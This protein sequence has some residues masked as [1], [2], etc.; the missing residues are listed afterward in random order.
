MIKIIYKLL[1]FYGED[2]VKDFS[3]LQEICLEE[4]RAVGIEPGKI[5]EWKLNNRAESR[6]GMCTWDK[7]KNEYKIQISLRLLIDDRIS[8]KA[9]KE[10]IIHEILHTCDGTKGHT[11]LWKQYAQL[12]NATYGYNIKR[13]TT[14]EEKGVENYKRKIL[15]YRYKFH[16]KRCGS[17]IR[18]KRVCKFTKYYKNYT[19]TLCGTKRA[20]IKDI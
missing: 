11:G 14:G 19:C 15:P 12:M 20:F 6:W 8:E 7:K 18:M 2:I 4:V 3:K 5:V 1:L 9:C 10:T 17:V 16:C 13:V